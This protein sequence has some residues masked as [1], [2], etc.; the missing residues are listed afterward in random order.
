MSS[1][2]GFEVLTAVSTKMA[3]F[4]VVVPCSMGKVYQHFTGSCCLH[5]Q[6]DLMMEAARIFERT[7]Q[8]IFLMPFSSLLSVNEIYNI[9]NVS[10]FS[11]KFLTLSFCLNGLIVN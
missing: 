7:L 1:F 9:P 2:V 8:S 3:V 11:S 6:D 10:E 4:S 5:H